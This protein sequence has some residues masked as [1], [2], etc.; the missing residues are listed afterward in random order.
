MKRL[1]ALFQVV[2]R[3]YNHRFLDAQEEVA[4]KVIAKIVICNPPQRL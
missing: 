3:S 2:S 1:Q 4:R